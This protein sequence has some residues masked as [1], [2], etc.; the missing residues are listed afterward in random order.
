[1][2]SNDT[3]EPLW[4]W[5]GVRGSART[6]QGWVA[7]RS[8]DLC[9]SWET[10]EKWTVLFTE[11]L[12]SCFG[13]VVLLGLFRLKRWKKYVSFDEVTAGRNPHKV[14]MIR[15]SSSVA[16]NYRVS[17]KTSSKKSI[18]VPWLCPTD[19]D[20]WTSNWNLILSSTKIINLSTLMP[21]RCWNTTTIL[22]F[23]DTWLTRMMAK[24]LNCTTK[25]L[26]L[27]LCGTIFSKM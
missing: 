3:I 6:S 8:A 13:P 20:I 9:C 25:V 7:Q 1:M 12:L 14:P 15:V 11:I 22:R 26:N 5:A 4:R 18:F 21:G 23:R 2:Q 10:Y 17:I 16:V 19:W 27:C 24:K